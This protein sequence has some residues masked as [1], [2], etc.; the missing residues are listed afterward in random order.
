[1]SATFYK[2]CVAYTTFES[3]PLEFSSAGGWMHANGTPFVSATVSLV[4]GPLMTLHGNLGGSFP[5]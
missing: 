3:R 2:S 1:M 5:D 4:A